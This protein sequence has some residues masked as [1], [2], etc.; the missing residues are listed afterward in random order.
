MGS[1]FATADAITDLVK[2]VIGLSQKPALPWIAGLLSPQLPLAL[3]S[4]GGWPRLLQRKAQALLQAFMG[5]NR[6]H[7]R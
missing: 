3:S 2:G 7:K 1:G 4:C 5:P 6:C